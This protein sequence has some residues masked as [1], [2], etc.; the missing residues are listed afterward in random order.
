MAAIAIAVAV[1]IV[2]ALL[3]YRFNGAWIYLWDRATRNG[4][5]RIAPEYE[6]PRYFKLK[7]DG[8]PDYAAK[9]PGWD[10]WYFFAIPDDPDF[11]SKLVRASLMTGLYGLDGI[12][13]YERLLLRL[14]TSEAAEYLCMAPSIMRTAS[15]GEKRNNFS[16]HYQP[17]EYDLGMSIG[18]LDTRISGEDI[19]KETDF[20]QYGRISGKWPDYRFQFFNPDANIRLDLRFR[21][22]N[23]IWWADL[24]DVFTYFTCLGRIEGT[25]T[26][27][28]GTEKPDPHKIP[29]HKETYAIRG[30]GGFEH[31][32]AHRLFSANRL[33][34]PVRLLNYTFP[35]FHP[36]RYHYEVLIGDRVGDK[37]L[38]GG[39]M[40]AR[41]FG[42]NV[43]DRGG[44]Y[45]DGRYI[46]INGVRIRYAEEPAPDLVAMHCPGRPPVA[47]YRKWTVEAETGEGVLTYT[48]WRD[49]PPAPVAPNMTY[50]QFTYDGSYQGNAIAGR[51]YG[52]YAHI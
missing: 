42:V 34:L 46:P 49:W 11:P 12:D 5:D 45:L 26:Y 23:L 48:A 44:L 15:G 10:G 32:F 39:F 35:S 30:T 28:D 37:D 1:I 47:F 2:A 25:I 52:E 7:P 17:K 8:T 43:R 27:Y 9:W 36:I 29:D 24:P 19:A 50:Y 18:E 13:N 21:G 20:L 33:F 51:G 3:L 40:L 14:S 4:R 41:A 6:L 38:R 22:E 16:Q 31:G